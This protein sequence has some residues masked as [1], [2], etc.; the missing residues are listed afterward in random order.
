MGM[1][2]LV[3]MDIGFVVACL[4]AV[5]AFWRNVYQS[6]LY[7]SA[8]RSLKELT[9]WKRMTDAQDSSNSYA[10]ATSHN[11]DPYLVVEGNQSRTEGISWVKSYGVS[12]LDTVDIVHEPDLESSQGIIPGAGYHVSVDTGNRR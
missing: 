10:M 12:D 9:S 4:P 8:S 11:L 6:A 5:G 2:G 1:W 7:A 3:E